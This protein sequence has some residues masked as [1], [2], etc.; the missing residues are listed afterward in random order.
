MARLSSAY[1]VAYNL[2]QL[3]GWSFI[4]YLFIPHFVHLL[5]SGEPSKKLYEDIS[6]VL[7]L[8]QVAAYLE[9]VH[10]ILGIVK[11]NP[12]ITGMQVTSRVFLVFICENLKVITIQLVQISLSTDLHVLGEWLNRFSS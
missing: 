6:F 3:V 12:V 1:M 11:S 10:S 5:G 9:V 7:G 4:F 8:F 2:A